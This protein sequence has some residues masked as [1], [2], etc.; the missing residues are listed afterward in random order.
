MFTAFIHGVTVSLTMIHVAY[1]RHS[2][3]VLIV[4][5]FSVD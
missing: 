2:S 4:E 5:H 1:L 3:I